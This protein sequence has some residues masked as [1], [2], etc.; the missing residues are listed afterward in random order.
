MEFFFKCTKSFEI[1]EKIWKK[2]IDK[3]DD[4]KECKKK[5]TF[6]RSDKTQKLKKNDQ[7]EIFNSV[8]SCYV[9]ISMPKP[10]N[11]KSHNKKKIEIR[12]KYSQMRV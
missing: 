2:M 8:E 11:F 10:F 4:D 6:Q 9:Q 12:S 7:T 5:K 3:N 1:F